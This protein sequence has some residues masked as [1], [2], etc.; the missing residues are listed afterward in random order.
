MLTLAL[1]A[2]LQALTPGLALA[3]DEALGRLFFS[4]ER[5]EAL[6]RQRSLNVQ[7]ARVMEGATLTVNG[8]IRRSSGKSTVW[9]NG[10][11]HDDNQPVSDVR[12]VIDR[13]DPSRVTLNAANEPP[14]SL[15]VGETINR[16]TREKGDGLEGGRVVVRHGRTVSHEAAHQSKR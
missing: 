14:A 8:I 11:P 10:V 7:Q 2:V 6:D 5:R 4:P 9:I 1:A 16:T 15:R 13:R 3:E 12:P